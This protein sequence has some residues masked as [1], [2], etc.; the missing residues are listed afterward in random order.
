MGDFLSWLSRNESR[1]VSMRTQVQYLALLSWLRIQ[2]CHDLWLGCR[3]SSDPALLG[4]WCS[5]AVTA[6]VQP[7]AWEPLYATV[8]P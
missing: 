4:L 8:R 3:L 2:H 1:L 7:L 5:L 6:P